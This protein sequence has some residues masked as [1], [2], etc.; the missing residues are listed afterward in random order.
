[1]NESKKEFVL[2]NNNNNNNI[3]DIATDKNYSFLQ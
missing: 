3:S 1:M 2:Y